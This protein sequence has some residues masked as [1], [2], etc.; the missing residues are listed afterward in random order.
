MLTFG[1]SRHHFFSR[2]TSALAR[3]PLKS[4]GDGRISIHYNAEPA[5]AEQLLRII[6]SVNQPSVF[7]AVAEWCQDLAQQ[8][9]FRRLLTTVS[10]KSQ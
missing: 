6:V 7:G 10:A 3:G 2:G 5:T 9:A 1:G 8:I 4:K